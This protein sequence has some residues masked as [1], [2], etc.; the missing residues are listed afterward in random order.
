MGYSNFKING[1]AIKN[2]NSFDIEHY[3][4]TQSTRVAN[5]D[6]MMDFVANKLKFNFGYSA[7]HSSDLDLIIEELWTKLATTKQCFHT[8]EY[9]ENG[10]VKTCTVYAGSI[11]KNLH[12]GDGSNWVWK[13]VKFSLIQQ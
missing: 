12:R 5:G 9:N 3:T 13:D 4:L 7:I 2:P 8:L 11:P 1:V 6:M 10:E